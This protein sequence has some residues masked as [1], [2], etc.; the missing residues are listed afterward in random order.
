MQTK[1]RYSKKGYKRYEKIWGNVKN[2]VK[3]IKLLIL[4]NLIVEVMAFAVL[5]L[6]PLNFDYAQFVACDLFFVGLLI[7]YIIIILFVSGRNDSK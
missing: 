6:N 1:K 7:F 2:K 5:L 3:K 4:L